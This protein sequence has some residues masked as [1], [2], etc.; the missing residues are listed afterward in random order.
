MPRHRDLVGTDIHALHAFTFANAT[1]RAAYV[2]GAADLG[3]CALDLDTKTFWMLTGYSPQAWQGATGGGGL[4]GPIGPQGPTG[5]QGPIGPAGPVGPA[6]AAGAAGSVG[7]AGPE[8]PQGPAGADLSP[9]ESWF[10]GIK[11]AP[12]APE[13]L[14]TYEAWLANGQVGHYGWIQTPA[15]DTLYV[16]GVPIDFTMRLLAGSVQTDAVVVFGVPL[17][18]AMA[19][20]SGSVALTEPGIITITGVPID[21]SVALLPGS[22]QVDVVLLAGVPIDMT[23]TLPVGTV[24]IVAAPS[25]GISHIGAGTVYFSGGLA[26]GTPFQPQLPAGIQENDLLLMLLGT[27]FVDD[28]GPVLPVGWEDAV[29]QFGGFGLGYGRLVWK[30]AGASESAPTVTAG[31]TDTLNVGRIHAFRGV[32][33]TGSP[34]AATPAKNNGTGT[35]LTGNAQTTDTAD[36]MIVMLGGTGGVEITHSTPAVSVDTIVAAHAPGSGGYGYGIFCAYDDAPSNAA[37]AKSAPT[38]VGSA[39]QPWQ[40]VT[41]ALKPA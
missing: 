1:E 11:L 18:I 37:G 36:A 24:E 35:A 14:I 23:L 8:G 30:R 25:T 26:D 39:S 19:M 15:S 6:G 16:T 3:K 38:V 33:A 2:F 17:D 7:P 40:T 13:G 31:G 22:V 5:A 20:L 34:F 32:V 12:T 4:P 41:L 28:G 29:A 21:M 27:S 10:K 9:E